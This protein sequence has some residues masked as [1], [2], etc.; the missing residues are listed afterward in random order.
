[1]RKQKHTDLCDISNNFSCRL[2][3]CLDSKKIHPAKAYFLTEYCIL[4]PDKP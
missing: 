3:I 1:L 2:T 4:N